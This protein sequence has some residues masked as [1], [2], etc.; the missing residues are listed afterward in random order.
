[1]A[2]YHSLTSRRTLEKNS[3]HKIIR[4]NRYFQKGEVDDDFLSQKNDALD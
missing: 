4:C 3:P 1:M 2:T